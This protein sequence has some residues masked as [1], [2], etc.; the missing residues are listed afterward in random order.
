MS[1]LAYADQAMFSSL[2][3]LGQ[4]P[5][6]Q[7]IWLYRRPL[8][9]ERLRRFYH[10]LG[11]GFLGRRVKRSSLP[12]GRHHW[13]SVQEPEAALEIANDRLDFNQWHQWADAQVQLPLDPE[14]GPAWRLT[15]QTFKDDITLV[16]LTIS[17]CVAD[18]TGSIIA[19]CEA[20]SEQVRDLGYPLPRERYSLPSLIADL[21]CCLAELP[22]VFKALTH[23]GILL[24][25]RQSHDQWHGEAGASFKSGADSLVSNQSA[26]GSHQNSFYLPSVTIGANPAHWD[27]RARRLGGDRLSLVVAVAGTIAVKLGRSSGGC[28]HLM[29]PVNIRC[30]PEDRG[31]NRLNIAKVSIPLEALPFDLGAIRQLIRASL[32]KS[33]KHPDPIFHV[34]PLVPLLPRWLMAAVLDGA[35][36]F[37]D[38]FP[39]GCTH[40]GTL[41]PEVLSIDGAAADEIFARG[42]DRRQSLIEKHGLFTTLSGAVLD[43]MRV[44]F[45]AHQPGKLNTREAFMEL[46]Q[47]ALKTYEIEA[48]FL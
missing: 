13:I 8:D 6:I 18:G 40:M 17:H 32:L 19:I 2:R 12:F 38:E 14:S 11:K 46:I 7:F 39:V 16:S 47:S 29:I 23:V 1:F 3:A 30:G 27:Q 36:N 4:E 26:I 33:R 31:A 43:K 21:G 22:S 24:P 48:F 28:V 35:L 45:I 42:V 9:I 15:T 5:I 10:C 41:T 25:K 20:Q 34:L 44:T 37:S